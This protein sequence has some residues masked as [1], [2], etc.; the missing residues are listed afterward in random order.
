MKTLAMAATLFGLTSG[1]AFAQS[2]SVPGGPINSTPFLASGNTCS[3]G[4]T[5]EFGAVC[6]GGIISAGPST[7]STLEL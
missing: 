5:D 7:E 2:C 4:A 6:G 1:F 3:G